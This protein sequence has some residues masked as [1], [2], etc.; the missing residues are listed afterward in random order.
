MTKKK[1]AGALGLC[2]RAGKLVAGTY[3]VREEVKKGRAAAVL[4][5]Q[6]AGL[7]AEKKL[8]RAAEERNVPV[9]RLALDKK[10]LG[11]CLGKKGEVVCVSVGQDFY[12]LVLA[13]L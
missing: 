10:E 6:D 13:S 1:Q 8:S 7:D 11:A 12:D 2:R 9:K 5:A 4:L 3:L